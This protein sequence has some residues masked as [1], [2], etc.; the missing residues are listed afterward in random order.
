MIK[1]LQEK[2]NMLKKRIDPKI[3]EREKRAE[4]KR[5]MV[6]GFAIGSVIA[7]VTAL[8]LSPDSGKNN[9]KKAKKELEKAKDILGTNIE[10]GKKKLVQVYEDTKE[11]IKDKKD[12][13]TE[14]LESDDGMNV[15]EEDFEE[16]EEDLTEIEDEETEDE[17]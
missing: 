3:I 11:V 17:Y 12:A 15:L 7:G 13:L 16:T 1:E 2:F 14:K 9:R 5:G 6:K 8:L 4:R 10:D